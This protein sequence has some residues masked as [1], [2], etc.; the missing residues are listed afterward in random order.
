MN[1]PGEGLRTGVLGG[2]TVSELFLDSC[3]STVWVWFLNCMYNLCSLANSHSWR[4][5]YSPHPQ[6]RILLTC[7]MRFLKIP[8]FYVYFYSLS[9]FWPFNVATD[10]KLGILWIKLL[11]FGHWW[12]LDTHTHTHSHTRTH[13]LYI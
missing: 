7:G 8:C 10:I 3:E 1:R 6:S 4:S 11:L 9:H 2:T 5:L 13:A 12:S